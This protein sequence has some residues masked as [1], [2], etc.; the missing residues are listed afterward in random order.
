MGAIRDFDGST[1]GVLFDFARGPVA[2]D[3]NVAGNCGCQRSAVANSSQ[4]P[5][6]SASTSSLSGYRHGW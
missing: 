4:R 1:Q 5:K 2:T 6:R 3:P